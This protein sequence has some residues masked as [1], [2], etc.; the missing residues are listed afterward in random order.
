MRLTL[1]LILSFTTTFFAYEF[2]KYHKLYFDRIELGLE[3]NACCARKKCTSDYYKKSLIKENVEA[4]E[5]TE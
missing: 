5:V 1:I 2:R 3:Y 4:K